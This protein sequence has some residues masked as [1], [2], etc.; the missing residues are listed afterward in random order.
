MNPNFQDKVA[1]VTGA[2]GTLCSAIAKHL[3][4]LGCKVVLVGRTREKLEKVAE[5]I[6]GLAP[7]APAPGRAGLREKPLV[8]PCDVTDEAAINALAERV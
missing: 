6:V 1:V 5:D 2:G 7:G 4:T 8:A 3:A